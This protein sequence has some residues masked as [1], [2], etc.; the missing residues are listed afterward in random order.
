V[1]TSQ[2]FFEVCG[3]VSYHGLSDT[4]QGYLFHKNMCSFGNKPSDRS[5]IFWCPPRRNLLEPRG[6]CPKPHREHIGVFFGHQWD[7]ICHVPSDHR[8][9]RY[10]RFSLT[11]LLESRA[12]SQQNPSPRGEKRE[13]DGNP[14][15]RYPG[16]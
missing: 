11:V 6:G 1:I 10:S 16:V 2:L 13:W 14:A 7:Q 4:F 5:G 8:A 9:N 3:L 15:H 12:T